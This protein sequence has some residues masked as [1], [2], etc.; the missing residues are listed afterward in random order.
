MSATVAFLGVAAVIGVGG[1]VIYQQVR[2]SKLHLDKD[3]NIVDSGFNG[4]PVST[5]TQQSPY[6]HE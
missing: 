1:L 6:N 3:G 5:M 2:D 4:K